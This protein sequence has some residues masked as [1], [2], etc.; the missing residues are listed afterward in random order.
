MI[1]LLIASGSA[2][3]REVL[4]EAV[5][6][7]P[8]IEILGTASTGSEA[9][10]MTKRLRPSLVLMDVRTHGIDAFE[11]TKQIMTEAPT[12]IVIVSDELDAREVEIS[13]HALRAGALSVVQK[14]ERRH[15]RSFTEASRQLLGTIKAM[16][17]VKLVRRWPER[18]QWDPRASRARRRIVAIAASTGGPAALHKIVSELPADFA[19]PIVV[20][21][22]ITVGFVGGLAA[23]LDL[24]SG[25]KV[26]MAEHGEVLLPGAVYIAADDR[27][28]G[29]SAGPRAMLS[30]AP[31][32]GGFRPSATF[33][34]DSVGRVFGAAA[35][36]VVL[37][38]MGRDGAGGLRAVRNGGGVIIAQDEQ[39]SV[40]F[41]M[42]A[43]AIAAGLTDAV[44]P[45]AEIAPRLVELSLHD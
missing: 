40:V 37:T 36:C 5:A 39:S 25:P 44:L 10:A 29:V 12:P 45:L 32:I 7:D 9:V 17:G 26:K 33:L 27:H 31:P 16:A 30:N 28:I 2:P 24:A 13:L 22:H 15:S 6:A 14:P 3:T 35:V 18:P 21:Q 41:G 23:W 43:A 19:L 34:F 20:V 8:G 38:G 11:A 4:A 42:P 1:R